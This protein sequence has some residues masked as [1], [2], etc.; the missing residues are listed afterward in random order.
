MNIVVIGTG[1]VGLVSGVCF[2]E[3][4]FNVTCIDTDTSKI[5]ALQQGK[6]TIYEAGLESMLQHN[7]K[8]QRL[9]FS[10]DIS[11]TIPF[12]NIVFIAVGTP[13]DQK[14][15]QADMQYVFAAAKEIAQNLGENYTLIVT[16]STVPVGTG[17]KIKN[18]ITQTNPN[19]KFDIASNPEF[20]REGSAIN[21][22]MQPDRI[23]IGTNST[24]AENMLRKLYK[25]LTN[26]GVSL[27]ATDIRTAEISK[28]AANSFLATKVTFINELSDLCEKTGANIQQVTEI[29]GK[30]PRIGAQFLNPGPAIGGSCFPKDIRA[31]SNIAKQQNT[32][33]LIIDSVILANYNRKIAMANKIKQ[34]LNND[35]HNKTIAILGVTFK[36]N[37]DDIRESAALT[38][39]NNLL[40]H[41]A[42][43]KIYDPKGMPAAKNYF[44]NNN[45][46]SF[47]RNSYEC[48]QDA[49]ALVIVTEWPEF[50]TLDISAI[51]DRLSNKLIIDLRNIYNPQDIIKHGINYISLGRPTP[52][53]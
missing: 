27:I 51:A 18:I 2:A 16:K 15:G 10:S 39:I 34:A 49:H 29:M 37:T 31:L 22:F 23:V 32:D 28:Y 38:I 1:Y 42:N 48:A 50:A 53:L 6:P 47:C 11:Q 40:K 45:A 3:L 4:G 9:H 52:N 17:D 7:A 19:A 33:L 5:S 24:S 44:A 46:I 43:I 12:A 21:D 30:D 25:P 36:A 14:T 35:I 13:P 26:R 41:N 8:Q 20:L